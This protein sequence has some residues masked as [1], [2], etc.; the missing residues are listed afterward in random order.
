MARKVGQIIARG[1]R[2][3]LIRVYLGRE[4]RNQETQLP[5]PN[6]PRLNAGGTLVYL[7]KKLPERD[8]GRDL[9]VCLANWPGNATQV[10]CFKNAERYSFQGL[11]TCTG[12]AT[13]GVP[14]L[15]VRKSMYQPG[16]AILGSL[17]RVTR[18]LPPDCRVIGRSTRR[19]PVLKECVVTP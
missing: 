10:A 12:C 9:A 13:D 14:S 18:T 1:D 8:L 5:Q 3:W 17:V 19:C 2:R 7:T 6:Y 11:K 16:G 15:S 4:P